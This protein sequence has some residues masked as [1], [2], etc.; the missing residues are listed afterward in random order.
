[1]S[2]T[3]RG[4]KADGFD[5]WS[6]RPH[7]GNGFGPITKRLCHRTER[8]QGRDEVRRQITAMEV[9]DGQD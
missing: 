7:S 3:V 5:F 6:R 2:R 9:S 1:M 4:S 8:L